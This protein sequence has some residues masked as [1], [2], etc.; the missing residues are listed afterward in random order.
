MEEAQKDQKDFCHEYRY[1]FH[2]PLD[3]AFQG[4]ETGPI[5]SR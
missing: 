5:S 2:A 3:T 4:T 1:G